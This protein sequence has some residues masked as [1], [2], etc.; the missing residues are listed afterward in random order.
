MIGEGCDIS[1]LLFSSPIIAVLIANTDRFP[2]H[3][4]CIMQLDDWVLCRIYK[5]SN[6][7]LMYS[8]SLPIDAGEASMDAGI[9]HG[10]QQQDDSTSAHDVDATGRL[11]RPPSISDYL[12]DYSAV[13]EL[14][15]SIPATQLGTTGTGSNS[16]VAPA[17]QFLVANNSGEASGSHKRRLMEDYPNNANM[18]MLQHASNKRALSDQHAS[19]AAVNNSFSM[20]GPEGYPSL[21]DRI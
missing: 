13:S 18:E 6:P 2:L 1:V 16:G 11:P 12:V 8:S 21:L 15:E 17:H 3:D 10:H 7:Q 20:F 4:R 9:N 19:M 5:K 14:F